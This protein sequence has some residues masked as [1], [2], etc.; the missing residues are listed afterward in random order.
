MA[1]NN[2]QKSIGIITMHKVHNYGSALQAYALQR[3]ISKLG[4]DCELIDYIYPNDYH[5]NQNTNKRP[6]K[7]L[8]Y[9]IKQLILVPLGCE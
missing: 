2:K 3:I 6:K 9:C 8:R 5:Y 4:F 1:I 7:T